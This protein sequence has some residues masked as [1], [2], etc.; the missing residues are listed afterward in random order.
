[1]STGARLWPWHCHMTRWQG[2]IIWH[3]IISRCLASITDQL[4]G[5]A[6]SPGSEITIISCPSQPPFVIL[7]AQVL[8]DATILIDTG[9]VRTDRP[10]HQSPALHLFSS[11][12]RTDKQRL[13]SSRSQLMPGMSSLLLALWCTSHHRS[14]RRLLFIFSSWILSNY[15]YISHKKTDESILV[16]IN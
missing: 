15:L 8:S 3:Q 4:S 11:L 5:S 9:I 13:I 12:K 2:D 7:T 14:Q 1:M 10:K 6:S 16:Q